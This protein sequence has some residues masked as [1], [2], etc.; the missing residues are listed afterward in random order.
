[1]ESLRTIVAPLFEKVSAPEFGIFLFGW[2]AI[3]F[4]AR[5]ESWRR[6]GYIFGLCAQPFWFLLTYRAEKYLVLA[7]SVLY[8]Y[9]W[10]QGVW[11]YWIKPDAEL[12]NYFRKVKKLATNRGLSEGAMLSEIF[13]EYFEQHATPKKSKLAA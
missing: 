2:A 8:A 9:S 13:H 12:K 1:M 11:F 5:P 3:W 7:V 10:A 4:V 6:W